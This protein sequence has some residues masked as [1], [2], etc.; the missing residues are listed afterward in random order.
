MNENKNLEYYLDSR[1]YSNEQV[2]ERI[3][4][5]KR[6][7][8]NKKVTVNITLNDFGMY[9]ITFTFENKNNFFNRVKIKIWRKFEKKLLLD[10]GCKN[11]LELYYGERR[12]GQYK[13]T[14]T[15]RPY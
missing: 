3:E 12:Y 8:S 10:N 4:N 15:Y 7:F 6:E 13:P 14:K 11:R 2:Q 5:T 1:I 9:V